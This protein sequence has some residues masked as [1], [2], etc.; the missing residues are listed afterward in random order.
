M[1]KLRSIGGVKFMF[2][3]LY[4][5]ANVWGALTILSENRLI[6]DHAGWPAPNPEQIFLA[7]SLIVGIYFIILFSG[8]SRKEIHL[9]QKSKLYGK[10]LAIVIFSIQ[11]MY[12]GFI[13]TYSAAKAGD[14]EKAGGIFRFLFYIVNPDMLF[15]IYY[16]VTMYAKDKLPYRTTNLVLFLISNLMRGWIGPILFIGFISAISWA[17]SPAKKI[18]TLKIFV[19]TI[20]LP[21]IFIIAS[22]FLYVKLAL[23][24]GFDAVSKLIADT[25]YFNILSSFTEILLSRLQLISSVLFQVTHQNELNKFIE[26]GLVG[27]FYTEG[28]PQQTIFNIFGIFPGENLNLFLWKNYIPGS[29]FE[30]QTTVQPGLAGWFYILSYYWILPFILYIL[31]LIFINFKLIN[32]FGGN[33]LRH[34]SWFA[35]LVFLIPGWFGAYISFLWSLLIFF[36]MTILIQKKTLQVKYASNE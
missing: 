6:A 16:S 12:I 14:I 25:S 1:Q 23:R 7:L 15:L 35:V 24:E 28:L 22:Y 29:F 33:G 26:N 21:I 36:L 32:F 20:L 4:I 18:T 5:L 27:N 19:F 2:V 10:A 31:F 9:K 34:L 13:F 17:E 11:A 30:F 3:A 8:K